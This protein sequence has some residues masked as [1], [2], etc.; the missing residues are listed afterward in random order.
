MQQVH[1]QK[2]LKIGLRE[3]RLR[4]LSGLSKNLAVIPVSIEKDVATRESLSLI[5]I[6]LD[7][8][9]GTCVEGRSNTFS[10]G[11]YPVMDESSEFAVKW[12]HLCRIHLSEGLRD[13]IKAVEY[14][15][16]FYVIEGHKRVSV[17]KYFGA[18]SIS[19]MVT[20]VYPMPSDSKEVQIYKEFLHFYQMTGLYLV[21]FNRLGGYQELLDLV[22]Y[23]TPWSAE[24]IR[25]FRAFF[26]I[27][28]SAFLARNGEKDQVSEALI[29]Y[30]R[31]YGY[32][33]AERVL[34]SVLESE[35]QKIQPEIIRQT[36]HKEVQLMLSAKIKKR[37]L[38]SGLWSSVLNVAFI[39]GHSPEQSSL[40]YSH[41][42]GRRDL[43]S[44]MQ[45]EIKT[46][47]YT[48]PFTEEQFSVAIEQAISEGADVIFVPE[49][50]MMRVCVQAAAAYPDVKILCCALNTIHPLIRTYYLRLYEAKF[51]TGALAGALAPGDRVAYLYDKEKESLIAGINAF[52][53][54]AQMTNPRARIVL[55][56]TNSNKQEFLEREK[57]FYLDDTRP[58]YVQD[59]LPGAAGLYDNTGEKPRNI[60]IAL[61]RWGKFYQKIL[62]RIMDGDWK[63]DADSNSAVSYWWG[64]DDGVID[65]IYSRSLPEGVR[66]LAQL[67]REAIGEKRIG[68]FAGMLRG[69]TG[70]I[71]HNDP[72]PMRAQEV[73]KMDWLAE[74]VVGS[75]GSAETNNTVES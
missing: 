58:D 61:C 69:Q 65:V 75:I 41:D 59:I 63:N 62:Y 36:Q 72:A 71:Y 43:E 54:G 38:I 12:E 14:M 11:F 50:E 64:M 7:L 40:I 4:S 9:V 30:L 28:A 3:Q 1:Y 44:A 19:G 67:L 42:L 60:A 46:K 21:R 34:P 29:A 25:D 39:Y 68:P 32:S 57:F 56:S 51:L 47:V 35:L 16:K 15:G 52:A 17:L 74:N 33:A 2:A 45:G 70:E 20:R 6:P 37:S 22:G 10:P 31:V 49:S 13:P 8:V 53:R 27:F 23:E 55:S 26:N 18:V 73:L 66:Q 5:D 24:H 48:V